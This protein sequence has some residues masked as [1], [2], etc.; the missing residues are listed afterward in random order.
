MYCT[1][2]PA[3][4]IS[5]PF[6]CK[7]DWDGSTK[8]RPRIALLHEELGSIAIIERLLESASDSALDPGAR[9]GRQERRAEILAE[10]A[11][12]KAEQSWF[13]AHAKGLSVALLVCAATAY[14][15]FHLLLR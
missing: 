6:R 1:A 3:E 2:N 14:V 4:P 10:I 7:C 15:T 13:E 8:A 12:L 11:R 9:E 5:A